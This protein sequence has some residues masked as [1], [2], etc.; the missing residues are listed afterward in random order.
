MNQMELHGQNLIAGNKSA[1]GDRKLEAIAAANGTPLGPAFFEAT[2]GEI[3]MAANGAGTAFED[4]R[5]RPPKER[6]ALLESIAERM[7]ALGDELIHRAVAETALPAERITGERGR[8]VGQ[9]RMFA[10]LARDGAWRDVRI[11]RAIEDRKPLRRPDLR[12]I[13]IPVGP[14]AI[15]PASN[16]PLA[17]SVAGGDTASA[18][19]AGNSVVVKAHPGHP[20]TSEM[21]G[22]VIQDAIAELNFPPGAF[23]MLHGANPEISLALV[24]HP[25]IRS[26]AFTGSLRAGRALFDAAAARPEPI[27]FFAEMG[28]VNPVFVLPGA[29]R[30]RS[31]ALA[32]GLCQSVNLGVGQFCTSPGLVLGLESDPLERFAEALRQSFESAPAGTMLSAGIRDAFERS[33]RH[34]HDIGAVRTTIAASPSGEGQHRVR[35]HLF[36][37]PAAELAKHEELLH[38]IF[39]PATILV[40]CQS[41]TEMTA[42]VRRMEGSLTATVHGTSADLE[43]YRSTISLLETKAG[44]L[45]FNGFP[46]GVEVCA[47][48][49]HGGPYPAT[50]DAR[51][52]SV[53]TAAIQRFARPVCYQDCPEALLPPEL[54]D[55]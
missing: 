10:E 8:T 4:M 23:S 50:T 41:V 21:V 24:R 7:I 49:Q 6:A 17:F 53:G 37:A 55:R 32:T 51:F 54:R 20:G 52:T 47:A 35:P 27:P 36:E 22:R 43:E 26:G 38:E 46:T 44:R 34:V 33:V 30:E 29:L 28:S 2:A 39:G 31:Q 18:L 42:F 9:L 5:L 45:I 15:W 40:R 13:L 11:D 16:F 1:L 25:A 3:D 14:V 48:M 12:R 19:A